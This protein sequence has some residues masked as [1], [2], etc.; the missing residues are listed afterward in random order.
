MNPVARNGIAAGGNWIVDCVKTVDRLPDRGMLGNILSEV[1]SGG[2]A[3]ANVLADLA[4]LGVG[5]PISGFGVVGDDPDGRFL[6]ESFRT[7]GVDVGGLA[8]TQAAPTS[9]TDVMNESG[10]GERAFFHHRGANALFEPRHVP[11]ADLTC[12]LFHLGYVLLLDHMDA[13][14]HEHGTVAAR[15]LKSLQAVGIKTSL[16]VVSEDSDR[17]RTVVPPA[18]QAVDYLVINEIEASRIVGRTVRRDDQSLDGDA[19]RDAVDVL[20]TLGNMAVTVV[21]MPEGGYWCARDGVRQA[22]GSLTLPDGFI[23][24]AV[25]AGD[26]FCA[27]I[28]LALHEGWPAE[29]ALHVASCCAAAA[30]SSAGAT[31]GLKPLPEVLA[32]GDRYPTRPPPVQV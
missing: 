3:P 15:L 5:F 31:D 9:Y 24:G 16:D 32:L 26:A 21:H 2:G 4:R 18:L 19:L 6:R 11:V 22:S 17:F 8:V 20:M 14:D 10:S 12:R 25:G 30:L 23:K 28:L 1:R 29:R 7:L 27:G 13:V